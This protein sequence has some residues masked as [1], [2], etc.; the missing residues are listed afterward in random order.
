MKI[1]P[2]LRQ[3]LLPVLAVLMPASVLRAAERGVRKIDLHALTELVISQDPALES[4]R[5]AIAKADFT[6]ATAERANAPELRVRYGESGF[7]ATG[8]YSVQLRLFPRHPFL[9]NAERE[10][11]IIARSQVELMLEASLQR[12]VLS[13]AEQHREIQ[14]MVFEFNMMQRRGDLLKADLEGLGELKAAHAINPGEYHTRR[15]ESLIDLARLTELKGRILDAHRALKARAGGLDTDVR[16][17]YA[18]SLHPRGLGL[19][20]LDQARLVELAL[21]RSAALGS[22]RGSQ[23][24]I[25]SDIK[26][27]NA[28]RIPWL[29]FVAVDYGIDDEVN[30]HSRD[31]WSVYTGVEFPVGAWFDGASRKAMD[32]RLGSVERQ[33]V[34]MQRQVEL[35][36]VRLCQSLATAQADWT[37]FS[38]STRKAKAEIKQQ[39]ALIA[40]NDLTARRTRLALRESLIDMDMQRLRLAH[41]LSGLLF[42]LCDTIGCDLPLVIETGL[43]Q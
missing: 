29:S 27:Q 33:K 30:E 15:T 18:G 32:E 24:G 34:L 17:M 20:G 2:K 5:G 6:V 26:V 43:S 16:I 37:T 1:C 7:G 19:Q 35:A 28:E 40:G 31:E 39:L 12:A 11:Q 42:E 22:L 41:R 3:W 4:L 38:G 21:E 10:K 23:L 8:S 9:K 14:F 36:V 25:E 13:V